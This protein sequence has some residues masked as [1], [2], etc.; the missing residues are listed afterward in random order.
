MLSFD[1]NY[2]TYDYDLTL[3][4]RKENKKYTKLNF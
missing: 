4:G 3:D 1:T 2:D